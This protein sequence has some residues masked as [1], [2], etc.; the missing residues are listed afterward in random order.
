MSLKTINRKSICLELTD[1]PLEFSDHHFTGISSPVGTELT[2]AGNVLICCATKTKLL[3]DFTRVD[4]EF[5]V[6]KTTGQV[7]DQHRPITGT[8]EQEIES[9]LWEKWQ[10]GRREVIQLLILAASTLQQDQRDRL[11]V[12]H[13]CVFPVT[14]PGVERGSTSNSVSLSSQPGNTAA[15]NLLRGNNTTTLSLP[16]LHP[17]LL[18]L[19]RKS[20]DVWQS[21]KMKMQRMQFFNNSLVQI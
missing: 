7:I 10:T 9:T 14:A 21:E 18:T 20:E 6:E 4:T 5:L 16:A 15:F 1:W 3:P 12:W 19:I 2:V 17:W 11:S 13:R 8:W